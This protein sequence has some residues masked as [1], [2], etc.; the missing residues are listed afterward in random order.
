MASPDRL[1]LLDYYTLLGLDAAA[2][3]DQIRAAYHAFALKFH[4]D[5][6]VG[7]EEAKLDRAAQIF[8]RGAEAYRVLLDPE[9][10]RR[11]DVGLEK[12]RLRFDPT[13]DDE[14]RSSRTPKGSETLSVRSIKARPFARKAELAMKKK[15]WKTAHLNLKIAMQHE[16]DNPLLEA[17]L[18]AVE[19][20]MKK[21]KK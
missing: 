18:A 7:G 6:H 11:Y 8:R 21:K 4:P 19:S 1:D 9:L 15:D 17:R 13:A 14:A 3:G 5:R 2:S 10:R 20:S 16:P 12:G